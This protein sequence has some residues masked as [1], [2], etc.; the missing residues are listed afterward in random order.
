MSNSGGIGF[1]GALAIVL[2]TLKLTGFIDWS[3]WWVLFPIWIPVLILG[4]LIWFV[5][6]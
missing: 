1:S 3:W 2:I 5:F 6:K 4:V